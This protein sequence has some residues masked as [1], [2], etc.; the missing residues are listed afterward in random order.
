MARRTAVY[1]LTKARTEAA[2]QAYN[3]VR[4]DIRQFLASNPPKSTPRAMRSAV[5]NDIARLCERWYRRGCRRGF[6]E[7]RDRQKKTGKMPKSLKY[8]YIAKDFFH[9]RRRTG[10]VERK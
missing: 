8:D 1:G 9:G 2:S 6:M 10:T 5:W 7:T 3:L 4:S